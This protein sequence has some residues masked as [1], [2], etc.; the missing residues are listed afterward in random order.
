MTLPVS[1]PLTLAQVGVE[2]GIP[3]AEPVTL[4]DA[5]VKIGWIRRGT[6]DAVNERAPRKDTAACGEL[7]CGLSTGARMVHLQQRYV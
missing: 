2:L 6:R 7:Q 5:R 1:P 4:N 3:V